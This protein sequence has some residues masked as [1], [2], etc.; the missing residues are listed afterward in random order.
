M[1]DKQATDFFNSVYQLSHGGQHS[2]FNA[3]ELG[4]N[5]GLRDEVTYRI[6]GE[7]KAQGLLEQTTFDLYFAISNKGLSEAEALFY[8]ARS[9]YRHTPPSRV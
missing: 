9:S 1:M 2:D 6:F 8:P 4:R 5:L 3:L 7:L